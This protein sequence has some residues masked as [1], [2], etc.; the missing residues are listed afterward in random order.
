MR[1]EISFLVDQTRSY[2]G[3][4]RTVSAVVDFVV[5]DALARAMQ[6]PAAPVDDARVFF[7]ENFSDLVTRV[8]NDAGKYTVVAVNR[9]ANLCEL[10]WL[11]RYKCVYD[12]WNVGVVF[13]VSAADLGSP[14]LES[15]DTG[16]LR[17]F[18]G[19]RSAVVREASEA[20]AATLAGFQESA[21]PAETS[22]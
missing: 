21:V 7:A 11:Y 3:D 2:F 1:K 17:Q 8:A 14:E 10:L 9:T 20:I 22:F 4:P 15:I 16:T 18:L 6:L 12:S 19:S 13:G 5:A